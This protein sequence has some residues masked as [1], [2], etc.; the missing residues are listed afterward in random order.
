MA[1]DHKILV[2]VRP[3]NLRRWNEQK[4]ASDNFF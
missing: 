3:N 2:A 1:L 4:K